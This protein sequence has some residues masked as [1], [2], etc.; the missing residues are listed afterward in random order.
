MHSNLKAEVISTL[1]DLRRIFQVL[2][3]SSRESERTLGVTGAQLFALRALADRSLSLNELAARTRTHQS[4]VS[5]VVKRLV[6]SG[7]VKSAPSPQD[8]RRLVLAL[9]P[10]GRSLLARAPSAAQDRL[11]QGLEKLPSSQRLALS[12]SL[13]ALIHEMG[14]EAEAPAMFFEDVEAPKKK[15]SRRA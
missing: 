13:R 5:V 8:A 14:L 1:D 15:R 4:T 6:A 3:E 7:L 12:G 2:R 10:R 9:T 11:I